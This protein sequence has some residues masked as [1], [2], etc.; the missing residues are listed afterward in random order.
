MGANAREGRVGRLLRLGVS[1]GSRSS[2]DPTALEALETELALLREE[3]ATL[4]VARHRPPDAGGIIDRMRKLQEATH[5]EATVP[6][7]LLEACQEVQQAMKMMRSRLNELAID[8]QG[9][10][11]DLAVPAPIS[12]PSAGEVELELAVGAPPASDLSQK[13]A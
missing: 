3:N 2:D 1:D 6:D 5:V 4:K 13:A 10:A 8:A 11:G 7:G 12:S 9:S